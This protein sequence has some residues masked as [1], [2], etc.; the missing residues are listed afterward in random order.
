MSAQLLRDRLAGQSEDRTR[1]LA[2]NILRSSGQVLGFVKEYLANAVA[3]HGIP[4]NPAPVSCRDAASAAVE[5]YREAAGRKQIEIQTDFDAGDATV[6]AD[7]IALDQVLDN[8]LSN[9]VKF[10]PLGKR[11]F[12]TVRPDK[13][14]VECMIQD[15]G[16]GFLPE[17]KARMFRRYMRL[18]AKPTG[19]EP[20][21]GLGLSI[22]RKLVRAMNGELTC[23]STPGAGATFTIRLPR[24]ATA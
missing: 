8:L 5:Q 22:A 1:Q 19:G 2:E 20:S 16:P 7:S 18:S 23:E 14:N 17:D 10:S 9:A 15:Q 24:S 11:I 4:I 3:D 21:T 13:D 12:V 6:L